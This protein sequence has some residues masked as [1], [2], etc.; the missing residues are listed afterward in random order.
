MANGIEDDLQR[1]NEQIVTEENAGNRPYF[2]KH[3]ATV[4]ALRRANGTF[5]SREMF[6]LSLKAGGKRT[7]DPRSIR[8]VPLGDS[9]ALVN[10]VVETEGRAYHNARVFTRDDDGC[11]KVLAWANEEL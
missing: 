3:L 8:V 9:R 10:C 6:L 1:L 5:D 4:F 11:W 7:C 2:E